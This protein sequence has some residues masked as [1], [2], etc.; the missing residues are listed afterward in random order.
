MKFEKILVTGGAGFIGSFL[1]DELVRR[2]HIVRVIDNLEPQVH[3]GQAPL[4]LN[5]KAEYVSGDVRDYDVLKKC[6]DGVE[7][8]FHEAAMVGVGQSMFQVRKYVDV[9]STGTATLLDIL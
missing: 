3:G 9:N 8:V 5:P 6:M 2:D 4:Y 1:V 7:A